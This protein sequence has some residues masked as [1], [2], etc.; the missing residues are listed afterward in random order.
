MSGY[1]NS[2]E[3]IEREIGLRMLSGRSMGQ[4]TDP[5]SDWNDLKGRFSAQ[6]V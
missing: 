2:N 6:R 3:S 4:K 1:R 5:L